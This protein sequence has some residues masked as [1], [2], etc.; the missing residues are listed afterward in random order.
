MAIAKSEYKQLEAKIK[1]LEISIKRTRYLVGIIL[2][3]FIF[4]LYGFARKIY[5]PGWKSF[6]WYIV[7]FIIGAVSIYKLLR[8]RKERLKFNAF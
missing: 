4:S 1:R 2:S 5:G 7:A 8:I 3:T 6:S